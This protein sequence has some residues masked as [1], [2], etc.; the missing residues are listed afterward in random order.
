MSVAPRGCTPADFLPAVFHPAV[1]RIARASR[2]PSFSAAGAPNLKRIIDL[3]NSTNYPNLPNF[4]PALEHHKY[5]SAVIDQDLMEL[6]L[7]SADS[8][9]RF[10]AGMDLRKLVGA[11]EVEYTGAGMKL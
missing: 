4:W 3:K 9:K 6:A 11:D 7:G 2:V 5:R 1:P 8:Q 10:E